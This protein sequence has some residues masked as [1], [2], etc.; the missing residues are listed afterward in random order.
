MEAGLYTW[1]QDI[2]PDVTF[3]VCNIGQTKIKS[4]SGRA[5]GGE[6]EEEGS[7]IQEEQGDTVPA[8]E[9]QLADSPLFEHAGLSFLS[10]PPSLCL[11]FAR[12][13]PFLRPTVSS[14]F[15]HLPEFLRFSLTGCMLPRSP[16][17]GARARTPRVTRDLCVRRAHVHV[18]IYTHGAH[19]VSGIRTSLSEKPLSTGRLSIAGYFRSQ[20]K[21][22][23]AKTARTN[24][25]PLVGRAAAATSTCIDRPLRLLLSFAR[26]L[27]R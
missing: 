11:P 17:A 22:L 8:A 14:P 4:Q 3:A 25:Q 10:F 2:R 7:E 21:I 18:E 20:K 19:P 9:V 1:Q 15:L 24:I 12:F 26:C 5:R 6:K 13:S 27:N 16:R 23:K